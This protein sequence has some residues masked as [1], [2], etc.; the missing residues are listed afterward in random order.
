MTIDALIELPKRFELVR[1]RIVEILASETASQQALAVASNLDPE[2]YR[3]RVFSERSNPWGEWTNASDDEDEIDPAPIVNVAFNSSNAD[4]S[5]GDVVKR[6]TFEG[7]FHIDCYGLGI[8]E[9]T[10]SGFIPADEMANKEAQ[11]AAA[12][13]QSILMAG[14][15]TYLGFPRGAGQIVGKRWIQSITSYEQRQDERSVQSVGA[16][17]IAFVVTF[18]ETHPQVNGPLCE[19]VDVSLVR[20][21]TGQIY[22]EM[23]FGDSL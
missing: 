17:R 19:G 16:V 21:E 20:G 14:I 6:Q 12:L 15:Y 3:I 1:D 11:R 8:A 22:A 10:A 4:G 9:Q 5:R 18:E 7:T 13:V 23:A 2:P